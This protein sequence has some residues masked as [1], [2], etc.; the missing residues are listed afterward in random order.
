MTSKR[1]NIQINLIYFEFGI[2]S[3]AL[4]MYV[5]TYVHSM[6]IDIC[7]GERKRYR[8]QNPILQA[9]GCYFLI[10]KYLF[11]RIQ[12]T[13]KRVPVAS[14]SQEKRT[15]TPSLNSCLKPNHQ[16]QISWQTQIISFSKVGLIHVE[17]LGQSNA[18]ISS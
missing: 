5:Y 2:I 6:Y 16:D 4:Y 8:Y 10:P 11:L 1:F 17:F 9:F 12:W 15:S 14:T 3:S 18:L 13:R 7:N